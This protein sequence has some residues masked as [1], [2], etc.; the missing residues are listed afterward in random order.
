ITEKR[1]ISERNLKEVIKLNLKLQFGG[2]KGRSEFLQIIDSSSNRYKKLSSQ[3]I[4]EIFRD[5]GEIYLDDLKKFILK[6]WELFEKVFIDKQLFE[7]YM[8]LI[9]TH[10]I[11]AHAKELED[12]VYQS[13]II[14]LN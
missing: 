8:S 14:A 5:K 12:D 1:G 7:I 6:K 4:D 9:N 11:D 13:V 10:R 3:N 2:I